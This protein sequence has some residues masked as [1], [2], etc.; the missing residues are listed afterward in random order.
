MKR[1]L[2]LMLAVLT[3]LT[4]TAC[5]G[6]SKNNDT[7]KDPDQKQEVKDENKEDKKEFKTFSIEAAEYYLNEAADLSVDDIKPDWEYTVGDYSAYGDD[8]TSGYGHAVI[9][10][11]KADG[12]VTKEEF[13]LWLEKVFAATAEASQDGYNVI[14]NEFAGDGENPL[15]ETTLEDAMSGFLQGWAF[16]Y[17]DKLMVVYVSH[18]YDNDKESE[19]G[20]I[21]YYDGVKVDIGVGLQTSWDEALEDMEEFFEDNEDEIEDAVDE[22]LN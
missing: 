17:N 2:I 9:K 19:I 8:P 5:A 7:N 14:G 12:E 22:Y 6:D 1:L 3:V 16:R 20:S 15:D 11:T 10:F 21:F 4:L 18:E 13:N